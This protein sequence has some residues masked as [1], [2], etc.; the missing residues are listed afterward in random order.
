MYCLDT[1]SRTRGKTL[2]KSHLK[3]VTPASVNQTVETPRRQKNKVYRPR[4]EHLTPSEVEKLIKPAKDTRHGERDSLMI[5]VCFRHG[6]R[7]CELVD[8]RWDQV[9]FDRGTLAVARAKNGKP[10]THPLQ[11]D[12]LRALR[13]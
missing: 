13:K 10:A 4:G 9:D 2:V 11:G 8:L 1:E 6:L 12:T 5:L 7:A 3:L